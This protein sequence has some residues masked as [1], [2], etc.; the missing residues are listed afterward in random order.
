[1]NVSYEKSVIMPTGCGIRVELGIRME[2][3]EIKG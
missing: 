1:M 2:L 3:G